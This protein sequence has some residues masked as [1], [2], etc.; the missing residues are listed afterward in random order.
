MKDFFKQY[1][2]WILAA[3]AALSLLLAA[4]SLLPFTSPLKDLEGILFSPIRSGAGAVADW[5]NERQTG[6]QTVQQ[7]REENAAL[8]RRL[9]E[10]EAA[11]R[12]AE[13]DSDEN[14]RLREL[15]NF[16]QRRR[17]LSDLEPA[18]V[19]EHAVT[20]WSETLTLD[21]GSSSGIELNDCVLDD[22]G[23]LVGFVTEL[24]YNWSTVTTLVDTETSLG[25]R[26]YR[27]GELGVA[28]GDFSLM[29]SGLMRMD[30][31]SAESLLTAGDLVVTS[32]LGGYLPPEVVIGSILELR[33]DEGG[34]SASAIIQP[35]ADFDSLVQVFVL[36]SF[37]II[38]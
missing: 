8:R 31:L 32:G 24:G 21:R 26:V 4:S 37:E 2:I 35:A 12:Q 28:V 3:A 33:L 9:A 20:N 27:T 22:T 14:T 16:V 11:V 36:K 5:F 6:R 13:T 19:T 17:D 18:R 10:M 15:L 34:A 7:L 25:A 1:G 23:A 38:T 30:Y 29:Q